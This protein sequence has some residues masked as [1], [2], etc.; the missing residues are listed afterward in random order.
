MSSIP[1]EKLIGLA[2]M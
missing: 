1:K 2:L